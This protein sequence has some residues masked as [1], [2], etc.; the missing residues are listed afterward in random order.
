MR[1]ADVDVLGHVNNAVHWTVLEDVLAEQGMRRLG[2]GEMEYLAP[3][4]AGVEPTVQADA[5]DAG[6]LWLRAGENV[7]AAARWAPAATAM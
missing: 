4:D 5:G 6:S 3:V 1:A 7:L 2:V